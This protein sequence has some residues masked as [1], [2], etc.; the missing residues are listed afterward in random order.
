MAYLSEQPA[1]S[2]SAESVGALMQ[3]LEEACEGRNIRLALR[4]KLQLVNTRPAAPVEMHLVRGCVYACG[5]AC[6][7]GSQ[8]RT[9]TRPPT[10]THT[11]TPGG[12]RH[13]YTRTRTHT[14]ARARRWW[15]TAGSGCR[16]TTWRRCCSWWRST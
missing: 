12:V 16:T 5:P 7:L 1:G 15:R 6:V 9:H 14:D 11:Q 10:H 8:S 13:T 3:A 4:E 2:A